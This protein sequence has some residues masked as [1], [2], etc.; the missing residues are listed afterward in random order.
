VCWVPGRPG[1]GW[2]IGLAD[3]LPWSSKA[4]SLAVGVDIE[5]F[6]AHEALEDARWA[7]ALYREI[8]SHLTVGQE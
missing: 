6:T 5:A 7:R 1:G 3:T 8:T 2:T 4:L